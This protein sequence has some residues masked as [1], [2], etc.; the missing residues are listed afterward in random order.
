MEKTYGNLIIGTMVI[1]GERERMIKLATIP[2][3]PREDCEDR[4]AE[5]CS[6]NPQY[7]RGYLFA[8]WVVKESIP[9]RRDYGAPTK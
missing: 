8:N 2:C 1:F 3:I 4:I 7:K 6:V 5:F 9:I